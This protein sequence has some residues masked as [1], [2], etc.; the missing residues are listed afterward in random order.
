MSR[1][2]E[3]GFTLVLSLVL[4]MVMSLM[5]GTLVVISSGD[6]RGNN[7]SDQ[8]QQAFYVAETALLEG[9][10]DLTSSFLGGWT[11]NSD[12]GVTLEEGVAGSPPAN[13]LHADNDTPCYKSFKNIT[14]HGTAA[15]DGLFVVKHVKGKKFINIIKP[16]LEEIKTTDVGVYG[17]AKEYAREVEY[18]E[19]FTY[20]FFMVNLGRAEY[21]AF[22]SSIQKT[23]VDTVS[24]GTA[25]K[26]YACG[27][28]DK[29][30]VIIPLESVIVLPA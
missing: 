17:S 19:D 4:L 9:E 18:L 24:N 2:N 23:S 3:K 6:H 11:L 8:Y 7:S 12:D 15:K 20:E 28:Y 5:G 13:A 10:K 27:I 21:K 30:E 1:K 29:D 16:I 22:G 25:Y 14:A 26:I